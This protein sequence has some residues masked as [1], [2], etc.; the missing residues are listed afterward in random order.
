MVVNNGV[1]F[2]VLIIIRHVCLGYPKRDLNFDSHTYHIIPKTLFYK[3]LGV[4]KIQDFGCTGYVVSGVGCVGFFVVSDQRL[5]VYD[6]VLSLHHIPD[7]REDQGLRY[8]KG[9]MIYKGYY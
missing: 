1:L 7:S 6:G 8:Y 5:R 2:W 9:S 4:F 3:H